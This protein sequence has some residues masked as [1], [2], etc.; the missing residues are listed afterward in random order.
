MYSLS[1]F[2]LETMSLFSLEV[3]SVLEE[4]VQQE[5]P[6]EDNL[7]IQK[8]SEW[9]SVA[10]VTMIKNKSWPTISEW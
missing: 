2:L 8:D 5:E 3:F 4:T 1:N 10:A 9:M 6:K 7:E